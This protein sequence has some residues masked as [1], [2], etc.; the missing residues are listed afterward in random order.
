MSK[1]FL[2]S[3]VVIG[4]IFRNRLEREAC[5]K[6]LPA[7]AQLVISK[8]VIFEIA[9]GF[10]RRLI[11]LH[12]ISFD[13][14]NIGE[15]LLASTSGQNRFS[16]NMPTW[17]G[18]I[19]DYLLQLSSAD[20]KSSESTDLEE[21]R[22]KIRV[23]IRKGWKSINQNFTIINLIG[24]RGF[25]PGPFQR[26]DKFLDQA[27]NIESCGDPDQCDLQTFLG[28]C[29]SQGEEIIVSLNSLPE[30]KKDPETKARL[31]S[32]RC[33]LSSSLGTPFLGKD[34]FRCGDAFICLEAPQDHVVASKNK[35]H[36]EPILKPLNKKFLNIP[37][38]K[39]PS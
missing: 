11:S 19:A 12:N 18:A 15:L 20:G 16:Y 6:N 17:T 29:T 2:D 22:A 21:F 25:T 26:S 4:L 36:F 3:S 35:K 1:V 30:A 23:W 9:R 7:D 31:K 8:Y 33:L 5:G 28:S 37:P 10:M 32:M 27:L 14:S 13:Y 38:K 34:C 24:C 39:F